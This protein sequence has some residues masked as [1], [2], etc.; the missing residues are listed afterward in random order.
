MKHKT[1]HRMGAAALPVLFAVLSLSG[2][3]AAVCR[4]EA[5]GFSIE[6]LSLEELRGLNADSGVRVAD[7]AEYGPAD[8]AGV[9]AGDVILEV[10]GRKVKAPEEVKDIL[11]RK[12]ES[13]KVE[14]LMIRRGLKEP[15]KTDPSKDRS[16]LQ[17]PESPGGMLEPDI[18]S[19]LDQD[20]SAKLKAEMAKVENDLY[21]KETGKI[22]ELS[23]MNGKI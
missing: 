5:F 3:N 17:I 23:V 14:I 12:K 9:K 1:I 10:D 4:T 15:A 13:D 8:K 22:G 21:F 2:A 19:E 6:E 18:Q 7:V 16:E 20:I 11:S